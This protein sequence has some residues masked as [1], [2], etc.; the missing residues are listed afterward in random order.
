MKKSNKILTIVTTSMIFIMLVTSLLISVSAKNNTDTPFDFML[1]GNANETH[2]R[3]KEDAS[4]MY[5]YCENTTTRYKGIA[6][7][8]YS[9]EGTNIY[10]EIDCSYDVNETE[11]RSRQYWFYS[12]YKRFMF[13]YVNE[14]GLDLAFIRG[15]AEEI[16]IAT[17]V[18]SPD[19]VPEAGVITEYDYIPF[20]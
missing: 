16:G 14:R 2:I 9:V 11:D 18:W 19:S 12:G 13:N 8:V 17:G 1:A 5:M 4:S 7:G 20:D 3:D 15:E 6:F 10:E